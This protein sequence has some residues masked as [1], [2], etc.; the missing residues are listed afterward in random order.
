M[1][2]EGAGLNDI[3]HSVSVPGSALSQPWMAPVYDEPEFVVQNIWRLYG[4][5]YDGNPAH[6]K[7]VEAKIGRRARSTVRG[8]YGTGRAVVSR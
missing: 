5:W 2:N 7:P 8:R 3:I 1:M 6:L 4:G